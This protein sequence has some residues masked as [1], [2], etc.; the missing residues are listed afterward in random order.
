MAAKNREM[1]INHIRTNKKH[2]SSF[3][4]YM[5]YSLASNY[6]QPMLSLTWLFLLQYVFPLHHQPLLH[7]FVSS[8]RPVRQQPSTNFT[9]Q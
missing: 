7:H 5:T 2:E 6:T 8:P 3:Q 9:E 1:N 4:Y